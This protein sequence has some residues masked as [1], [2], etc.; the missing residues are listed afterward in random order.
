MRELLNDL[1]YALRIHRKAAGF[2]VVAVLTVAL[3]ISAS[4]TVFSAVKAILLTPLPYPEPDRIVALLRLAPP[5]I[6]YTE[7]PSGRVDSLFYTQEAKSF[8]AVGAF[9]GGFFNLTGTGEPQRVDGVR[10]SAGFYQ[11]LGVDARLGRTFTAADDQP[12][13]EHVVVLG[14]RLWR[15]QFGADAAV[16]GRTLQLNGAGYIVIGVMPPGFDFPRASGMP[17]V[18]TLPRAAE[19]WVPL[20]LVP[21][22][23]IRGEESDLALVARMKPRVSVSQAQAEMDLLRTRLEALYPSGKGWFGARV[24]TLGRELTGDSRRP[25]WFTLVAV[26]TLLLIACTNLAGLLITRSLARQRELAVRIALGASRARLLRQ[27]LTEYL[28]LAAVGG[29][30]GI[31]LTWEGVRVLA[32]LGPSEVPRLSEAALDPTVI[33]FA[34]GVTVVTGLLFGLAPAWTAARSSALDAVTRAGRRVV[35]AR[36]TLTLRQGLLLVEIGLAVVLVTAAGL[37]A[38]TFAQL[39]AVNPGFT[40]DRVLTFELTLSNQDYGDQPHVVALYQD[41][42]QYLRAV[43][44]IE[45]AAI[46]ETLPMSGAPE[47]T[48]VRIPGRPMDPARPL[49]ANYTIVSPGY[50]ASVGTRILRGR[51]ILESDTAMSQPVAVINQAMAEA[52]WPGAD[53]IGRQVT[54]PIFKNAATIVGI[55]P[56]EKHVSLGEKPAPEMWVPFSQKVWPSMQTMDVVVR[57]SQEAASMTLAARDAVRAA[58]PDVPMARVAT[59]EAVVGD[60]LQARRFSVVV[61]AVF[62]LLALSLA[63]IGL[64]GVISHSVAQRA[65]E[66]GVRIALGAERRDV[67]AMVVGQSLRLTGIGIGLGLL[68]A[69]ALTRFIEGFLYGVRPLD[70]ATFAAV[71]AIFVAVALAACILPARRAARIDAW[72]ALTTD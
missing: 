41:V 56:D 71:T 19:L 7:F 68:A 21:G 53:P 27:L 55:V 70:P 22:P 44:G 40:V 14:D 10:A 13:H 54:P 38:R 47:S 16:V 63:S 48:V 12:G 51:D 43:P 57:T 37:L 72:Q 66:I 9:K 67:V 35:G 8:E 64:F 31:G 65:G 42:L 50:F 24:I 34:I 59:L 52:Y 29:G 33:A 46:V 26:A 5:G 49:Y 39:I 28:L 20:A 17:A 4:A 1:K 60:S 15:E 62:A 69:A 58:A 36:G 32:R 11:A 61:I 45:S 25:L 18:L 23:V 30:L 6:G 2:S 3:G